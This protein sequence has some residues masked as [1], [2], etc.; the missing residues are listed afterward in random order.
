MLNKQE[1]SKTLDRKLGAFERKS[2][3]GVFQ[4]ITL[5][6]FRSF[7]VRLVLD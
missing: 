3:R 4:G 5:P 6:L 7:Y 2:P 1:Q